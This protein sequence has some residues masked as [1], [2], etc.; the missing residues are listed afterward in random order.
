MLLQL[1]G[2][3]LYCAPEEEA[4]DS[5]RQKPNGE[6][7]D[8]RSQVCSLVQAGKRLQATTAKLG[9]TKV[10]RRVRQVHFGAVRVPQAPIRPRRE[11][12]E[13]EPSGEE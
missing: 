12:R 6:V 3:V 7:D 1:D 13:N 10:A 4:R 2:I 11:K 9:E 8:L 5:H